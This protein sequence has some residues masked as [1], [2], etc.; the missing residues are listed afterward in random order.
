MTA[1]LRILNIKF[2]KVGG[3]IKKKVGGYVK[4]MSCSLRDGAAAFSEPSDL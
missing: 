3:Y 2:A 4:K 1:L